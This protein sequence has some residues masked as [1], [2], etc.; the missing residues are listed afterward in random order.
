MKKVALLSLV[1][2]SSAISEQIK[3]ITFQG[4]LYLSSETAQ[5]IIDLRPGVEFDMDRI[6]NAIRTLFAQQYFE[7]ILIEE[8]DGNLVIHVKEKP[9]IAK[10]EFDGVA[11][12]DKTSIESFLNVK[13]GEMYDVDKIEKGKELIKKYFEA[14][15]F[16]DTIVEVD[17]AD[18]NER[19]IEV[20]FIVN[21]GE[22]I[23]IKN[24]TVHGAK[25]LKYDDFE[26]SI[27][28]KEREF[29]GWM[30]GRNDGKVNL[31]E[32][33][34]DSSRIRDVYYKKG[35]LDA[36]VSTP[37][38][39]TYFDTYEAQ[40]EYMIEEGNRYKVDNVRIDIPDGYIDAEKVKKKLLLQKGDVFDVTKLRKDAKE[41]ENIL[42]NQGYA[43]AKVYPDVEKNS[44]I[45]TTDL[46]FTV[47]PSDKVHVRDVRIAGNSA[48]LDRIIR[49]DIYL[50]PGDLYNR[51]ELNESRNALRRTSYFEDV[52]F[53]EERVSESQIDLIANIKEAQTGAIG[54]GIGYGSSDGF[55][56]NGYLSE[57]N[58]LGSGVK[59]SVNV[60][61][62]DKELSGSVTVN[63]PRIF[64]SKYS[65][66]GSVYRKDFDFT[67]YDELTTGGYI[68]VGRSL[69][70]YVNVGLKY[71]IENSELSNMPDNS[72]YDYASNFMLDSIK[73]SIVPSITFNNTDDYFTPR[74]GVIASTSF[75]IAGIGGD[76]EFFKSI[77]K[78][79]TFYGFEDL[80][81][82]DL[83]LRYK[84]QFSWAHDDGYLPIN[85]RLY[86]GGTNTLRGFDSRS[87]SPKNDNGILLGGTLSFANSVEASIPLVERLKMRGTLFFDYGMIGEDDLEEKRASTGVAIEW[88]S[89]LGPIQFIFSKALK[90]ETGD[91]TSSFEFTMGRSF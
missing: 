56:I 29:M 84:A 22:N 48:T 23:I 25:K 31:F 30:W 5:E 89:P 72:R 36:N 85:E 87:I 7:D 67:N 91:D 65:L 55:L 9:T 21:R 44:E 2:A 61:R 69:G 14:K 77:T 49:R 79:A 18:L 8:Q 45:Y 70:R 80:I 53:K 10:V 20:K 73:S 6:D 34:T 1:I 52:T 12:N 58:I 62:S 43:Y 16:F 81:G 83:I 3:S 40:L 60:E 54:G 63:N 35:Y 74:R 86:L 50:A 76:Q 82:Y 51:Q 32:I 4:L 59:A 33:D 90:K 11:E 47:I 37:F 38:L 41:I 42:A 68:S 24:V 71:V 46:I 78:F 64:D 66:G 57:N 28:N 27:A 26:P 15:G 17:T 88:T 19:S 75:E 13:K 39:K